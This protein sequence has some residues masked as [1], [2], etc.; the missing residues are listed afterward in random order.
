MKTTYVNKT[1]I[2]RERYFSTCS[3]ATTATPSEYN[4]NN[5]KSYYNIDYELDELWNTL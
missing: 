3:R 1:K 5:K 4:T 2:A